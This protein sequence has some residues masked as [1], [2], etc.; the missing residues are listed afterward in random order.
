M[1]SPEV[2]FPS[3]LSSFV[4]IS[5]CHLCFCENYSDLPVLLCTDQLCLLWKTSV[6]KLLKFWNFWR[7]GEPP[8]SAPFPRMCSPSTAAW[9]RSKS[10]WASCNPQKRTLLKVLIKRSSREGFSKYFPRTGSLS[11]T[12]SSS[13]LSSSPSG[14][15]SLVCFSSLILS[16]WSFSECSDVPKNLQ[17]DFSENE[18]GGAFRTSPKIHTFW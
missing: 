9:A 13:A 6:L 16:A 18:G 12:E 15:S 17:Y 11:S 3:F 10:R 14:R 7:W 8:W 5:N 1:A 2:A 4:S